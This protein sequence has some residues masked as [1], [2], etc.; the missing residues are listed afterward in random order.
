MSPVDT[1]SQPSL[2]G[3]QRAP[4]YP[5]R[6]R[7]RQAESRTLVALCLSL[8]ALSDETGVVTHLQLRLQLLHRIQHDTH[9]DQQSGTADRQACTLVNAVA[10]YGMTAMTPRK[11]APAAVMRT[12]TRVM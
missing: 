8:A 6:Y 5:Y 3:Q 10:K 1:C 11:I 4:A 7:A 12:S 9:D 2:L